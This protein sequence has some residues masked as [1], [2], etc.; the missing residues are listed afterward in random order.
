VVQKAGVKLRLSLGQPNLSGVTNPTTTITSSGST[1]VACVLSLIEQSRSGWGKRRRRALAIV[2]ADGMGAN[3]G[4]RGIR[5]PSKARQIGILL[6]W[7]PEFPSKS[8]WA[9]RGWTFQKKS[10]LAASS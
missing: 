4:L 6:G 2:T 3:E 10:F 8:I 7:S 5:G 9:K 1:L